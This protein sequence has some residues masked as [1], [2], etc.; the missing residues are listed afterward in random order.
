MASE[1]DSA[2]V[3]VP[4]DDGLS[5]S[6]TLSAEGYLE[7]DQGMLP[8]TYDE[9]VLYDAGEDE[10]LQGAGVDGVAAGEQGGTGDIVVTVTDPTMQQSESSAFKSS[11]VMYTVNTKTTRSEFSQQS[12]SVKRR[13]KDFVSL[14][15]RLRTNYKGYVV[16]PRPEKSMVEGQVM[17][18]KD[19]IDDRRA[20]L[21]KY[22]QRLVLHPVIGKSKELV[23]FL[24]LDGALSAMPE[25]TS[26]EPLGAV[27]E[28]Q[29]ALPVDQSSSA[30][31]APSLIGRFKHA[32]TSIT[33]G[34]NPDDHDPDM[35]E[36]KERVAELEKLLTAA[37]STAESLLKRQE[38]LGD[39]LGE[40]GL[41]LIKLS[42]HEDTEAARLGQYSE[43]GSK[44]AEHA[45]DVRRVGT[46]SVRMSRLARAADDQTALQLSPLHDHLG[47][48]PA[49]RTALNDRVDA[50]RHVALMKEDYETRSTRLKKLESGEARTIFG[51]RA[52]QVREL[53]FLTKDVPALKAS[54]A[55]SEAELELIKER[56]ATELERLKDE[57]QIAFA[58][59]LRGLARVQAAYSDRSL[60]IWKSTSDAFGAA[61][62]QA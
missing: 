53:D 35:D 58:T 1:L 42:K 24:Q 49:A 41:S 44:I 2:A 16:P 13:F 56:N 15:D 50:R 11:F 55:A 29:G 5:A 34:P 4:L 20:S 48:V 22:L 38:D 26:A 62:P 45:A 32:M 18:S 60:S 23:A 25:W 14:A 43:V 8:P 31:R 27:S 57:R 61:P 28:E 9:S 51:G 37:S 39:A 36:K 33:S 21:E 6:A 17:Q 12:M 10:G 30:Q 47:L 46:A 3:D 19:F 52:Q 40:L 59:M 54:V 7:D